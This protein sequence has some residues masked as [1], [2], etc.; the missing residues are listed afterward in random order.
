MLIY[1]HVQIQAGQLVQKWQRENHMPWDINREMPRGR[2]YHRDMSNMVVRY[3]HVLMVRMKSLIL[4]HQQW[5]MIYFWYH[6]L[7]LL[8]H[9]YYYLDPFSYS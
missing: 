8:Q 7:K 2:W 1:I 5:M 9:H 3:D 4:M 6:P